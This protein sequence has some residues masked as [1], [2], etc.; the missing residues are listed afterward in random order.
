MCDPVTITVLA[1]A[2]LATS[3]GGTVMGINSAIQQGKFAKGMANYQA[4]LARNRAARAIQAGE[5]Q[6][7]DAM[8]RRKQLA[9]EGQVAFAGNGVLLDTSPTS[10]PNMWDQDQAAAR[11][12]E[13]ANIRDSARAEAWGH[14]TQA[15]MDVLQ[16]S[17]ARKGATM[18][19]WGIGLKGAGD[20][21]GK[22]LNTY[23]AYQKT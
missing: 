3:I 1:G 21:I 20:A 14:S 9:A 23:E 6:A 8:Q 17:M 19:A 18:D 15:T 2:A 5:F 4:S 12:F 16:G 13:V 11:A 22:G 10:A 7:A